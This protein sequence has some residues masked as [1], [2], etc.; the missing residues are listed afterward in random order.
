[1]AEQTLRHARLVEFQLNE[2]AQLQVSTVPETNPLVLTMLAHWMMQLV[3]AGVQLNLV[4]HAQLTMD[5]E[6]RPL[7]YAIGVQFLKHEN[8]LSCQ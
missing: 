3:E 6:A 8:E 2:A 7:V 1:M 5:P 4:M